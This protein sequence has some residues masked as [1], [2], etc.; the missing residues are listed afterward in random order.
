MRWLQ[1][2]RG[3]RPAGPLPARSRNTQHATRLGGACVAGVLLASL[4]AARAQ[5]KVTYNDHVLPL[6]EQHCANC[7]NPDKKKGDLVL[8]SYNALL[9]GGGSGVIVAAGSPDSSK[10]WKAITHAEEPTMPPKKPKLA[11]KDLDVFKKWI[12]GGL[13]ETTGSKAVAAAK[14][15]IDL[16]M[17]V[18]SAGR[19]EGPPPMPVDLPIEP[20]VH[21]KRGTAITGL[22]ASPWAPLVAIAGQKQ[23]L[24][25]NTTNLDLAGILPF[26][27]G[28]PWDLKFSRS[29]KLLLAAGGHGAKSGRVVLWNVESGERLTTLGEEYDTILAADISPDQSKVALGGPSR[30]VK[31]H[32]TKTGEAEHKLKKHTDWVSAV[33]FSPNGEFLATADRNGGVVLWDPDN[34]QELFTTAG[35]KSAVTSLSWRDDS[36]VVASSSEDGSVKLWETSEGKQARTWNAH[37]SGAMCVAFSHE[38]SSVTCGRDGVVTT[39][40]ADGS[41][42]KSFDFFGETALR[43]AFSHDG[44]RL[45][46]TD[47]AGRVA[48]WNAANGKRLGTLD[49]NPL[50]LPDQLAAAQKRVEKLAAP[51][52]NPAP[53]RP[54]ET[55]AAKA[56]DELEKAQAALANAQADFASK[57]R[58]VVRLKSLATTAN[59]PADIDGLL[60]AARA[61]REEARAATNR[62]TL[63]FEAKTREASSFRDGASGPPPDPAAEL[64]A[65][66]ATLARLVRA[67]AQAEAFHAR[68]NVAARKRELEA[69]RGAL[70]AKQ[71]EV[72]KLNSDLGAAKDSATKTRL[73]TELKSASAA[74]KETEAAIRKC[75]AELADEQSR[76]DRAAAEFERMKTASSAAQTQSKL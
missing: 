38:G 3:L 36:R 4:A 59:P 9:K 2:T 5:E 69:L 16:T 62:A 10:L 12:I 39:W 8:T 72:K 30:L 32:S 1:V 50:L 25:F 45:I 74:L 29:G 33:A 18:S 19:P 76:A 14:P 47:F 65:A 48:V 22:A 40:N 73:R 17:K 67:Q 64:A 6:I 71:D 34:G 68:E 24:L 37:G 31:I 54:E 23:V 41:K 49:A 56:K 70:A 57:A 51:G 15:S 44:S 28:Q 7:H 42:L 52:G 66:R 46:A 43:C 26:G 55:A 20:V 60:A 27:E 63:Q 58:E 35:H 21:A 61:A 13:L 75:T 11:D 53:T